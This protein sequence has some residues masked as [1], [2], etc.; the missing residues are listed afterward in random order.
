MLTIK[1]LHAY[2]LASAA[3]SEAGGNG[4]RFP[5]VRMCAKQF[6][7]PQSRIEEMCAEGIDHGYIDLGVA[8]G[9]FGGVSDLPR[10]YQVVEA[11]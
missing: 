4:T 7:V 2:S 1:S 5:T 8:E 3:K 11:G 9:S 6:N 10:G